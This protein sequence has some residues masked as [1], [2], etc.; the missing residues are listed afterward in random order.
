ML[1]MRD[2]FFLK[3]EKYNLFLTFI[4]WCSVLF[5]VS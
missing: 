4:F 3:D 1:F 2:R 5:Y